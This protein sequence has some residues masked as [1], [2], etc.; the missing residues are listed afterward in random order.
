[1][2]ARCFLPSCKASTDPKSAE[3][4][5]NILVTDDE[6]PMSLPKSKP[7]KVNLVINRNAVANINK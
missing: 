3:P 6:Q 5:P 1:M 7:P 4:E 2:V